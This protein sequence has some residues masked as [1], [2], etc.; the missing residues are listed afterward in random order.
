MSRPAPRGGVEIVRRPV[1]VNDWGPD[2]GVV[3]VSGGSHAGR[4]GVAKRTA[5]STRS[6]RVPAGAAPRDRRGDETRFAVVPP[7]LKQVFVDPESPA[8]D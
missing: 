3:Y 5:R 2:T 6:H 8:T 7:W 1:T 4:A